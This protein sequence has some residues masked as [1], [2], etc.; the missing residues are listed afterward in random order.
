MLTIFVSVDLNLSLFLCNFFIVVVFPSWKLT[1]NP[2]IFGQDFQLKC[3]L[4]DTSAIN[5]ATLKNAD[6]HFLGG[7]LL[8]L[9]DE[10]NKVTQIHRMYTLTTRV[11]GDDDVTV[12]FNCRHRDLKYTDLKNITLEAFECKILQMKYMYIKFKQLI[13]I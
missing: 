3:S 2:A 11:K 8:T 4:N 10:L 6:I 13:H 5:D 9:K 12:P 1:T 7:N